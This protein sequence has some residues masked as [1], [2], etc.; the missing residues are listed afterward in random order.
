MSAFDAS[1]IIYVRVFHKTMILGGGGFGNRQS[2]FPKW[3]AAKQ[4]SA[5]EHHQGNLAT[6]QNLPLVFSVTWLL[7]SFSVLFCFLNCF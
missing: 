3:Q 1:G 4:L 7:F 5:I 6:I 2:H